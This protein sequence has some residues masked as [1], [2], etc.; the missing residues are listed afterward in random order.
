MGSVDD[1]KIYGAGLL[2]SLGESHSCMAPAV[3]KIPLSVGCTE[4]D[5]DITKPQPQLFVAEDFDHLENVLEDFADSLAQRIGGRD[6]LEIMRNSGEC[7][8]V[9]FDSGVQIT[10]VL[11]EDIGEEAPAYLRFSGPCALAR[12]GSILEGQGVAQHAE[13]YGTPVGRLDDGTALSECE[14][15]DLDRF[16]GDGDRLRLRY[17]SGVEVEGVLDRHQLDEHGRLAVLTFRD[18]RVLHGDRVLFD[19]TWGVYDLVVGE[20]V[21]SCFAGSA[22]PAYYPPTEFQTASVPRPK[23]PTTA[24]EEG[25]VLSLYRRALGLWEDSK[26]PR[27]VDDFGSIASELDRHPEEWLLRWNLAECLRKED[28]GDALVSS[29]RDQMLEIEK[30]DYQNL[31]ITTG[32]RYLGLS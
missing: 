25:Q 2:S 27:L 16:R 4:T 18:C 12:G 13:G 29:L 19:P 6:A 5:Y 28:R 22:D 21:V 3:K 9:E 17:A 7:G 26:S 24:A 8:T 10:G 11:D 32:L 1:Y 30:T 23:D 14:P 20:S 31:P 15:R